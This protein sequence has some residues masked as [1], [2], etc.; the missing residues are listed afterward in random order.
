MKSM[1]ISQSISYIEIY[2]NLISRVYDLG[3][4]IGLTPFGERILR[5]SVLIS[6]APYINPKDKILDLCCGTG[7]LTIYLADLLYKN[8]KIVGVDISSGQ[9]MKA[10]R[11]N[12]HQNLTFRIMDA[13]DLK[14]PNEYFDHIIISAA[15]HEM[16]K[17]QRI[18]VLS[19]IYRVLKKKGIFLVFDHHEPRRW[20]K[21]IL[22][23]FYLGFIEKIT[24]N[25]FEMQ[26]SILN[27]IKG[28]NFKI[29]N[30][31]F[32]KKFLDFFQIIL[33]EKSTSS[34]LIL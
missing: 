29:I 34:T 8:C 9:I 26:R 19:E 17:E 10:R 16:K 30:Q 23:N 4:K 18:N 20:P 14:F 2:D 31:S 25:S 28:S 11:K 15:L 24:S 6:I 7:T 13:N 32:I 5:N 3:L 1:T 22:Y 12:N 27:E 21:R 33:S